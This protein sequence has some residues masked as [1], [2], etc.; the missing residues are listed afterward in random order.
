MAVIPSKKVPDVLKRV[1]DTYVAQKE[2]EEPFQAFVK[3]VGK[4]KIKE[5]IQDLCI[6]SSIQE[7]PELYSDWG[8]PRQF[9]IGD[10]GIG[11]CAGEVV[12]PT[13]FGL[14]KSEQQ[15]FEAQLFLDKSDYAQAIA[16]AQKS[17]LTAARALILL[18]NRN[19]GDSKEEILEQFRSLYYDTKLFFDPYAGGKFASYIFRSDNDGDLEDRAHQRVEEAQLFIEGAHAC[20]LRMSKAAG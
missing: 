19:I 20:H 16:A 12:S 2:S 3:R 10:M 8:D 13:E 1:T 6:V 4:A 15:V 14:A 18:K 9:S 7:A 5:V 17:M 11:E